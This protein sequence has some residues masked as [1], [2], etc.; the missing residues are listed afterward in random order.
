MK[1]R[2]LISLDVI[3][4]SSRIALGDECLIERLLPFLWREEVLLPI[5]P[6][7]RK[8]FWIL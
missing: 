6:L 3:V 8:L 5:L 7:M 2:D 1:D 4:D